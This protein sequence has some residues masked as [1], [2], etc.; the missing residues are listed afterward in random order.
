[1]FES[2]WSYRANDNRSWRS[3]HGR[4]SAISDRPGTS[5]D[6]LCRSA[7]SSRISRSFDVELLIGYTYTVAMLP[8]KLAQNIVP[9]AL[10]NESTTLLLLVHIPAVLPEWDARTWVRSRDVWVR[11]LRPGIA[12]ASATNSRMEYTILP[13]DAV[14]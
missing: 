7:A 1:M 11:L 14:K 9:S 2:Q 6:C 13:G 4:A 10:F 5:A 8:S 3:S 12:A